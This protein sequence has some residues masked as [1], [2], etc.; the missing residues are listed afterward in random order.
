MR[1]P[2]P[3]M[4]LGRAGS[5]SLSAPGSDVKKE[6]T[7]A[8]TGRR[9]GRWA[10]RSRVCRVRTRRRG[11]AGRIATECVRQAHGPLR[12][13]ERRRG[14]RHQGGGGT[15]AEPSTE[16]VVCFGQ[17][18]SEHRAGHDDERHAGEERDE[19]Q[20]HSERAELPEVVGDRQRHPHVG[21]DRVERDSRGGEQ[22][23]RKQ[24]PPPNLAAQHQPGGPPPQQ[25][26]DGDA[27]QPGADGADVP[28]D[29][30]AGKRQSHEIDQSPADPQ[31]TATLVPQAATGRA[32]PGPQVGPLQCRRERHR[33][34][35]GQQHP[36]RAGGR[37]GGLGR[38]ER[39][40]DQVKSSAADAEA[41]HH[42]RDHRFAD[43]VPGQRG[44]NHQQ[45]EERHE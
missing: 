42:R 40:L 11:G 9:P 43:G 3:R 41:I 14:H 4:T 34:C 33:E 20:C 19:R 39:L 25:G 17:H 22:C 13:G 24:G 36:D 35:D 23:G 7:G 26:P 15:V 38:R 16:R 1:S 27:G 5:A 6:L 29:Q 18:G 30:A 37:S 32:P 44:R 10:R 12:A 2:P 28:A 45:W 31:G 21:D 8:I